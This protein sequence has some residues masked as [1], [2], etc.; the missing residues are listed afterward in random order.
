[1][2]SRKFTPV[3]LFD[4]GQYSTHAPHVKQF[5][6]LFFSNA[7]STDKNVM[8]VIKFRGKNVPRY[9]TGQAVLHRLQL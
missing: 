2:R 7:S 1:M 8:S 6:R 3:S 4:I 9:E 5:Q